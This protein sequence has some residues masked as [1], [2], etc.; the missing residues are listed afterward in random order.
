[1]PLQNFYEDPN[2][3]LQRRTKKFECI[4]IYWRNFVIFH[5]YI[6]NVENIIKLIYIYYVPKSMFPIDY[7]LNNNGSLRSKRLS[8]QLKKFV[9]GELTFFAAVALITC[10]SVEGFT[11]PVKGKTL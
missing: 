4:T 11:G 3:D 1:M 7:Y 6:L 2:Y 9:H 8:N 10:P 5:T